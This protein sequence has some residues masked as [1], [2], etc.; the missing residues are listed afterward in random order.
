MFD[1]FI[2]SLADNLADLLTLALIIAL[3][4]GIAYYVLA[5]RRHVAAI[6]KR[7]GGQA[8]V[9]SK[10]REVLRRAVNADVA[11]VGAIG[12]VTFVDLAWQYSMADPSIWEHFNGP[13][14]DHI[15]DALQNLDVLKVAL[16]D[17]ALPLVDNVI[18]W[19]KGLEA[20][21]V[22]GDLADKLPLIGD[23]S[24]IVLDAKGSS[25]VDSLVGAASTVHTAAEA[26]AAAAS[27]GL[28]IHLPL[29]TIGFASYRAWRRAQRGAG[30]GRN[31]EF[32]AIEV[33][34]RAT[35]GLIGGKMGGVIGTAIAPG[36]GTIFG[37]VAGAVGGA[38]GGALLGE[39]IKKRHV[40][41]AGRDLN[42]ALERLGAAYLNDDEGFR[43]LTDVFR[44]REEGYLRNLRDL[45]R[46][47]RRY[48]MPWRLVWPDEKLVLLQETVRL[49]EQ[50]LG[51]IREGTVAALD[52]LAYMRE[53]D[54]RRELGALLLSNPALCEA[55]PCD[56]ELVG[57]AQQANERFRRELQ[58]M[59][60]LTEGAAA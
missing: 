2:R 59:G 37:T 18:E 48:A 10:A 7:L 40:E 19:L 6:R 1:A 58:H 43:Q 54:Q 57:A 25:L 32:A 60:M 42:S 55:I 41:K 39:S 46:R 15:T 4:A 26:K 20:L 50:R 14:A 52:K 24:A 27:G 28:S 36:L 12:A 16:G 44:A 9:P 23:A 34:T 29:V 47:L 11:E 22:F 21:H 38:I 35:G 8:T 49:A 45:K 13:A 17:H 3:A 51:T 53:T 56:A 31:I 33:G 5:R 30:L